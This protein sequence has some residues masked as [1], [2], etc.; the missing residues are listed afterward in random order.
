M[1]TKLFILALLSVVILS[2]CQTRE[3]RL[4]AQKIHLRNQVETCIS[5]EIMGLFEVKFNTDKMDTLYV[6]T[7]DKYTAAKYTDEVLLQNGLTDSVSYTITEI[8][9]TTY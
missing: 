2:S 7:T 3:E 6:F 1:K 5:N 8:S 4:S 9:V